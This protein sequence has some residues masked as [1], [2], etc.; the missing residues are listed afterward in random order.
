MSN[1]AYRVKD[2][3]ALG[4]ILT[5][6][7]NAAFPN[8]RRSRYEE[9]HVLLLSW[10]DDDL[11]VVEEVSELQDVFRHRYHYETEEWK[12]PSKR[13]HNTLATKILQF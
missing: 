10:K 3:K 6:A 9:A 2:V 12:I 11:R 7:G 4:K 13:P 5:D 1:T 8:R